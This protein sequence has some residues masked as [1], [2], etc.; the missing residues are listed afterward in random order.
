MSMNLFDSK[1]SK[2]EVALTIA[3][4]TVG[5][6]VSLTFLDYGTVALGL[7]QAVSLPEA[8][9]GFAVTA[10][11]TFIGYIIGKKDKSE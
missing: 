1:T 9:H 11:T 4:F 10:G 6:L 5:G 2:K 7:K 8:V 3:G